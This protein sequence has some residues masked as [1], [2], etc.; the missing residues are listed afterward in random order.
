MITSSSLSFLNKIN[1]TMLGRS[2][3]K[4]IKAMWIF[5][6]IKGLLVISRI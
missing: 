4:I 2:T 3:H 1:T 5:H 6:D